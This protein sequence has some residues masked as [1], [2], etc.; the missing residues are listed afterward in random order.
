MR[1]IIPTAVLLF[2]VLGCSKDTIVG[3][4][5]LVSQ[6]REVSSFDRINNNG[7]INIELNQGD[8]QFVE[9]TA[10][11]NVIDRVRTEVVN[12]ELLV[13]LDGDSFRDIR[14]NAVITTNSIKGIRNIGTGDVSASNILGNEDFT[15][16]N[17]GTGTITL[18]GSANSLDVYNEGSGDIKAFE[19]PVDVAEVQLIGSGN[20]EVH[21]TDSMNVFIDGSGN[22][23]YKGQPG[24]QVSIEGSGKVIDSN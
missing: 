7:I 1:K 6:E 10:D 24:I 19:F 12:G 3:S 9:I 21:C 22:V 13:Y 16:Y 2:F 17:S 18:E 23:Y 5:N 8:S 4:G 20:C 14:I 15:L 11:D